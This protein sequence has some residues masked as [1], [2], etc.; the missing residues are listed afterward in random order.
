MADVFRAELEGA[1]GVTRELVIKKVLHT[2]SLDREAVEMFVQEARVAARLHHPNVVQVYEFGRAGDGYFLAME[3]VEGCDLAAL[4]KAHAGAALPLPA[5]AWVFQELLEA[6]G[7]VHGLADAGGKPLGLVHRDISP[8]NV[9]LGRA[10]E[11]KL[12]DFGIATASARA[13]DEG[14]KGK[15]AYMAPEQARGE[16]LDARADL[17]AVG[18]MLYEA[19]AGRR[20]QPTRETQV[21]LD[22]A[23]RGAIEP[24]EEVSPDVHPALAAVVGR[25][26]S[27]D[28]DDR[29]PDAATFRAALA[30]AMFVAG[31]APD[32]AL[33]QAMVRAR[34]GEAESPRADRTLTSHDDTHANDAESSSEED[35][36]ESDR[37][38]PLETE[39]SPLSRSR[40]LFER[41]MIA[42]GVFTLAVLAERRTRP[43]TAPAAVAVALPDEAGVRGWFD[44]GGRAAAAARCR[45]R[46]E[47]RYYRSAAE[48]EGWLR[49]GDVALAAVTTVTLPQVLPL[50]VGGPNEVDAA[51]RPSVVRALRSWPGGGALAPVAVD[52]VVMAVGP[53]SDWEGERSLR[54][55]A[56]LLVPAVDARVGHRPPVEYLSRYDDPTSWTWWDVLSYAWLFRP[57]GRSGGVSLG[58]AGEAGLGAWYAVAGPWGGDR[59]GA[60]DLRGVEEVSAWGALLASLGLLTPGGPEPGRDVVYVGSLRAFPAAEGW[61]LAPLPQD[62]GMLGAPPRRPAG[63]G[64]Y[65]EVLGWVARARGATGAP[66]SAAWQAL[67]SP[68]SARGLAL[69]WRGIPAHGAGGGDVPLGAVAGQAERLVDRGFSLAL[70]PPRGDAG[71]VAA[72]LDRVMAQARSASPQPFVGEGRWWWPT[73][74]EAVARAFG[75]GETDGG[76]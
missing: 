38:R 60:N 5:V 28:P 12:A 27:A 3:L 75:A 74:R 23:R 33:L 13:H 56:Q 55:R 15:F 1:E 8:H 39:P 32:R 41:A 47:A 43:V 71:R 59:A 50:V 36:G 53:H 21:M 30:E 11:V 26:V 46:V 72:A 31:A 73:V 9:L 20:A 14:V 66:A 16:R 2:L 40:R 49:R 44:G 34:T 10:G 48:V 58:L 69:A 54:A 68:K 22:A 52:P 57:P 29:F 24:L 64:V 51:L 67:R 6:L 25:A 76:L 17:Y 42:V 35:S 18:A 63:L 4:F 61:S 19:L 37:P 62:V 65:G 7:Y 45:C 70:C